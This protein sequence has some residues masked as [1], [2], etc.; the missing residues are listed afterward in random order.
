VSSRCENC[1]R[2][3]TDYAHYRMCVPKKKWPDEFFVK[4]KSVETA[5]PIV[6]ESR[7]ISIKDAIIC[8]TCGFEAKSDFGMKSHSR[9]HGG[10][11]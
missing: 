8:S 3:K 7:Q 1:Y 11:E 9:K 2:F 4:A 6:E 5:P 10:A